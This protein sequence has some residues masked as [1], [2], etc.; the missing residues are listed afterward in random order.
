[1]T[2]KYLQDNATNIIKNNLVLIAQENDTPYFYDNKIR[3]PF[4]FKNIDDTTKPFGYSHSILKEFYLIR[5]RLNN[6]Y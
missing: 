1:M 3:S 5:E 6:L 4:K 2:R